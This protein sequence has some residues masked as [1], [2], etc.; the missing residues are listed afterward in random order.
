MGQEMQTSSEVL[1]LSAEEQ[2]R[3][4]ADTQSLKEYG[5]AHGLRQLEGRMAHGLDPSGMLAIPESRALASK[6]AEKLG[7]SLEQAEQFI[8]ELHTQGPWKKIDQL[9]N[10][11]TTPEARFYLHL[12]ASCLEKPEDESYSSA[13]Y[14]ADRKRVM[15]ELAIYAGEDQSATDE[16]YAE[17]LEDRVYGMKDKEVT[18]VDGQ[19]I[20]IS[21]GDPFIGMAAEGYAGGIAKTGKDGDPGTLY[22]VASEKIDEETVKK[23]SLSP[24][25]AEVYDPAAQTMKRVEMGTE[26]SKKGRVV[27]ATPDQLSLPIQDRMGA[28]K[29]I[30]AGYMLAYGNKDLA[31]KLLAT[32]LKG[33]QGMSSMEGA[34]EEVPSAKAEKMSDL[35]EDFADKLE[36]LRFQKKKMLHQYD[37]SI[38]E[39]KWMLDGDDRPEL[40]EI[41]EEFYHGWSNRQIQKLI[42]DAEAS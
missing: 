37:G 22:F 2:A 5:E 12:S 14:L 38:S 33:R 15:E 29:R 28:L 40:L 41:R 3:L 17:R 6:V 23:L 26:E 7:T 27:Y 31:K 42:D 16:L 30:G 1:K 9:K 25:F 36:N 20:V 21:Q 18:E 4:D 34:S 39:L 32:E 11:G 10:G 24:A 35:P 8:T 13:E 19:H